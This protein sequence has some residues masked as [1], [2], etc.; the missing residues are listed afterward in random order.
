[1]ISQEL[2]PIM[3]ILITLA[4]GGFYLLLLLPLRKKS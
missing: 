2:T 4:A 3:N 1:M